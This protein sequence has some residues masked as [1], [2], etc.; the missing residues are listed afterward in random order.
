MQPIVQRF[1]P[2]EYKDKSGSPLAIKRRMSPGLQLH[3]FIGSQFALRPFK[4][5][6]LYVGRSHSRQH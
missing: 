2:V 4:K 6:L 3:N 5:V 1:L